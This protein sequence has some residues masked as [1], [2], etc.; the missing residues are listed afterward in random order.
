MAGRVRH[1]RLINGGRRLAAVATYSSQMSLF[2]DV[3]EFYGI[4]RGFISSAIEDKKQEYRICLVKLC[5]FLSGV[6]FIWLSTRC[7][8]NSNNLNLLSSFALYEECTGTVKHY[9]P[10]KFFLCKNKL[11]CKFVKTWIR[12]QIIR[13]D[14]M[15]LLSRIDLNFN[16]FKR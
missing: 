11:F 8:K 6:K 4:A 13:S 16:F 5:F 7:L 15:I 12:I 1:Q 10:V 3:T 14:S 2:L 9:Q